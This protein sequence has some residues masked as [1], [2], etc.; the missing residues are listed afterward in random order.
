[1]PSRIL[2]ACFLLA[3]SALHA[4]MH[5]W[6]S[7]DG[8]KSIQGKFLKRD[9]SSVTILRSDMREVTIPLEKIHS[10]DR[11][12]LD[13]RYPPPVA[14]TPPARQYVFD[15]LEFGDSRAQVM[16]KLKAS[17]LVKATMPE[18]MFART[19]L[20][21][22][23]QTH[24][25]IGGLDAS[26][27]FDWSANG[28]LKEVTLQTSPVSGYD[29]EARLTPSWRELIGLLTSLH[30]KPINAH[31]KFD[32]ASIP[33]GTMTA[34][35]LWKLEHRGTAML[36]AARDGDAWQIAVRFTTEDIK[37]VVIPADTKTKL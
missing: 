32:I 1:M 21:G 28:L 10:D 35:H 22:I 26:L 2:V 23:F 25:K 5:A 18:T 13:A 17:K 11:A 19:G 24:Q 12:W 3:S 15:K 16:E 29:A 14:V 31:E 33:K 30:G 6:R 27:Y 20:N 37:P 8:G 9:K 4:E 34:T 36:G 7:A